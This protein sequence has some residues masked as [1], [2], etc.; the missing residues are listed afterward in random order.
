[1]EHLEALFQAVATIKQL[2]VIA[3]PLQSFLL[4]VVVP[5]VEVVRARLAAP[6]DAHCVSEQAEQLILQD[7]ACVALREKLQG[8]ETPRGL[9]LT[10]NPFTVSGFL[11]FLHLVRSGAVAQPATA[12]LCSCVL[13]FVAHHY[14]KAD[15]GLLT[16]S[17]KVV[18]LLEVVCEAW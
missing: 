9:I 15:N 14:R 2:C 18:R 10:L 7:I 1:V 17:I 11:V 3:E 8:F 4:A 12:L 5:N 16:G 6:T 13:R